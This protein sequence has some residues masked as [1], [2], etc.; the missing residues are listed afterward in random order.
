MSIVERAPSPAAIMAS[1]AVL[2]SVGQLQLQLPK[3][4]ACV[5]WSSAPSMKPMLVSKPRPA[6]VQP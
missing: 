3:Q 6:G 4:L 5:Q 1:I 2:A